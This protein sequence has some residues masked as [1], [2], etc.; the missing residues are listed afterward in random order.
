M[1]QIGSLSSTAACGRC[2]ENEKAPKHEQC[3]RQCAVR[4]CFKSQRSARKFR[5][6]VQS[7]KSLNLMDIWVWR[8]LVAR[9]LGVVEAAGSSPVTQ[10]SMGVL[11]GFQFPV[12]TLFLF[13]VFFDFLVLLVRRSLLLH[14]FLFEGKY[15]ASAEMNPRANKFDRCSYSVL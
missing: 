13:I 1:A 2:R 11:T 6:N 14:P 9:Y 3:K 4:D 8:R 12:R 15:Q 5:I 10:T 7:L